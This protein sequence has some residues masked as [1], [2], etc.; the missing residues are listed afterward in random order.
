MKVKHLWY[1]FRLQCYSLLFI[2][3]LCLAASVRLVSRFMLLLGVTGCICF[4]TATVLLFVLKHCFYSGH[5]LGGV[6]FCL[7]FY[8]VGILLLQCTALCFGTLLLQW[9]YFIMG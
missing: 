7:Y 5:I 8:L 4:G 6:V 9:C 2:A 3:R 1:W